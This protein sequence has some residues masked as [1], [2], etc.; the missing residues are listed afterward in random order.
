MGKNIFH[1]SGIQKDFFL[2]AMDTQWI[3]YLWWRSEELLH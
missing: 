2:Y 3:R 1:N